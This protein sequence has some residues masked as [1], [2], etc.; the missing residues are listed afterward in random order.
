MTGGG[1]SIAEKSKFELQ[2]LA[3]RTRGGYGKYNSS[4]ETDSGEDQSDECEAED[5]GSHQGD[6]PLAIFA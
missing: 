6:E 4:G 5:R 2:R 3:R 1:R